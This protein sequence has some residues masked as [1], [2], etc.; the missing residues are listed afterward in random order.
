MWCDGERVEKIAKFWQISSRLNKAQAQLLC[1]ATATSNDSHCHRWRQFGTVLLGTGHVFLSRKAFQRPGLVRYPC[2][3][4]HTCPTCLKRN[5]K[6]LCNKQPKRIIVSTIHICFHTLNNY[7]RV[8]SPKRV[9]LVKC[10]WAIS[11]SGKKNYRWLQAVE[12]SDWSKRLTMIYTTP[13]QCHT[14]RVKFEEQEA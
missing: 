5:H 14:M 13:P 1:V 2:A 12:L 10:G 9:V 3:Y 8:S 7:S 6:R 4:Y 11:R